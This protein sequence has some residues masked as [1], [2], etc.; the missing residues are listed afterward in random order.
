MYFIN[1]SGITENMIVAEPITK[2]EI[3]IGVVSSPEIQSEIF[4]E[5]GK[6]F[7]KL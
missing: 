4:I 7:S 5:R 3:L 1:S 6:D 2:E